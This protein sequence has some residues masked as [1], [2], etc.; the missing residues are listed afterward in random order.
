MQV[1]QAVGVGEA[2]LADL[3]RA[4]A[5]PGSDPRSD[6]PPPLLRAAV[7]QLSDLAP[8]TCLAGTVRNV[9]PFGAFVDIGVRAPP[10][11]TTQPLP[12]I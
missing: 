3:L 4:I 7:T 2:T 1:A 9:V 12:W 10:P 6:V 11:H 8:G 5:A